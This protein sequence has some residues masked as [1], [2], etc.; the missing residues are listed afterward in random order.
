MDRNFLSSLTLLIKMEEGEKV[1]HSK[2]GQKDFLA[3]TFRSMCQLIFVLKLC[4]GFFL[5]STAFKISMY[6]TKSQDQIK[7]I[8]MKLPNSILEESLLLCINKFSTSPS[9]T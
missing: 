7:I 4:L 8:S 5:L 9:V 1:L 2:Q 6:N 3:Q